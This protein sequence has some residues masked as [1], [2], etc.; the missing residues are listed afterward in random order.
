MT[1]LIS[2]YPSPPAAELIRRPEVVIIDDD[3]ELTRA[4]ARVLKN[5]YDCKV[6]GFTSVEEFLDVLDG[7]STLPLR[8]ADLDVILLDFHLPGRNGPKLVGELTQR[9]SSLLSRT[10]ILGITAD[11]EATVLTSFKDAGI[12]EILRKPLRKLDFGRIAEQAYKVC[13]GDDKPA[14]PKIIKTYI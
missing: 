8:E 7:K 9:S 5:K 12:D 3:V 14:N 13:G 4:V 2:T 1:R 10:R 6:W 11:G